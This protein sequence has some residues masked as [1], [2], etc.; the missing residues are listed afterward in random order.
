MFLR[1]LA[2]ANSGPFVLGPS[3]AGGNDPHCVAHP[4]IPLEAWVD[5]TGTRRHGQHPAV[6]DAKGFLDHTGMFLMGLVN[7][8]YKVKINPFYALT[9]RQPG[10][11]TG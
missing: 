5:P 6:D 1:V 4:G 7:H 11:T 2:R 10:A 3:S 9:F 8:R